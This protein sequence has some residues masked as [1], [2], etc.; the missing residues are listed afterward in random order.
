MKKPKHIPGFKD[1]PTPRQKMPELPLDK[2]RLNFDEVELG[3]TEEMVLAEAARCLSCRRC[4]GCGLCLAECDQEAVIYDQQPEA[5]TVEADAVVLTSD[6]QVF[7]ARRKRELGYSAC[8][9][10]ITSYEFERLTSPNGPFGGLLVRPFDGDVPL[11]IGFV[12]CVGSRD[13]AIGANYCSVECC[14]RTLAQARRARQ[15]VGQ[16][17]VKVFHKGLRPIGKTSEAD[18]EGLKAEDWVEFVETAVTSVVEDAETGTLR[19]TY[20][21]DEKETS[22][23]LDLLVLAVG[24]QAKRDFRQLARAGGLKTNKFGFAD[25]NLAGRLRA[26]PGTSF[27]GAVCGPVSAERSLAGAIGSAG[28]SFD[29]VAAR[30]AGPVR[31]KTQPVVFAC[32][33]GLGLAGKD[34][35]LVKHL[36]AAG[37]AV[38]GIFPFLCYRD[39]RAAMARRC[40]PTSGLV[41]VGCHA[42]S[43]ENL[44][45]RLLGLAA[46]AVC[47]VGGSDLEDDAAD[48]ERLGRMRQPARGR[49]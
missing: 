19:V 45:E 22:E 21:V 9:N 37:I 39:G 43:H 4:I 44:F 24:I 16:A 42:S 13:E 34:G 10:V 26:V 35:S 2:R 47:I 1:I 27:A 40:G 32:E 36:R 17:R 12:Q 31:G 6:G 18:L 11:R 48:R 29:R 3:L 49:R 20:S 25:L 7:D 28:R 14:S 30:Q 38:E 23:D 46:G 41:V 8:R 5:L 33:Y 15:I